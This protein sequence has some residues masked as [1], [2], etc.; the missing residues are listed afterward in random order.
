MVSLARE[1]QQ[2]QEPVAAADRA[3]RMSLCV[4]DLQRR[5]SRDWRVTAEQLP[6]IKVGTERRRS[7]LDLVGNIDEGFTA[8][9]W[10]VCNLSHAAELENI[11]NGTWPWPGRAPGVLRGQWRINGRGGPPRVA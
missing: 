11:G 3:R 1:K 9:S 7:V 2:T 10:S 4:Q 5:S 6:V 8:L